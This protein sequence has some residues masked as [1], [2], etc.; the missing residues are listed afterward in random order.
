M[1]SNFPTEQRTGE[2]LIHTFGVFFENSSVEL[3]LF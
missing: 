1:E 3:F 2:A